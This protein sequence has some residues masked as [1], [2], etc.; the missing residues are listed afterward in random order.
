[1]SDFSIGFFTRDA[2]KG[3]VYPHLT[4]NDLFIQYNEAWVGKLSAQDWERQPQPPNLALSKD[5]PLLYVMHA[6]DHGFS[7]KVLHE[8]EI[9]LDFDISYG[10]YDK[11]FNEVAHELYGED[12]WE[13]MMS[14]VG[15]D[16]NKMDEAN[17]ITE[18]RLKDENILEKEMTRALANIND[19]RLKIFEIFG[20]NREIIQN[21]KQILTIQNGVE[22]SRKMVDNLL[23]CIGLTQL[24]FVSYEYISRGDDDR[25][26]ILNKCCK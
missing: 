25:F 17:E 18:K 4:E 5:V 6:E 16:D 15:T 23:D 12:C 2:Y 14:S 21:L 13:V 9:K 1:M 26:E 11:V 3:N 22:N 7:M 24:E 19:E 20:F 10:I 8:E